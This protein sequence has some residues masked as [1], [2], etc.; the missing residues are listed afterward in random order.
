[1]ASTS[2]WH[3]NPLWWRCWPARIY[4]SSNWS[5]NDS[6]STRNNHVTNN[7]VTNNY[8]TN[9]QCRFDIEHYKLRQ[10]TLGRWLR[11][12]VNFLICLSKMVFRKYKRESG[13]WIWRWNN[14]YLGLRCYLKWRILVFWRPW[15]SSKCKNDFI[16][17]DLFLTF[18]QRV[19]KIV[20]C[21]LARQP[22]MAF[23]LFYP[24]CNTFLEPTPKILL[25]F[26]FHDVKACHS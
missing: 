18:F 7:H 4:R 5:S 1:M 14:S 19:S 10:Y 23:D 13:F 12:S 22:N 21:Q 20:D 26:P 8:F 3:R 6:I 2:I 25:C 9:S 15:K 24:A 16:I 11:W 17:Y